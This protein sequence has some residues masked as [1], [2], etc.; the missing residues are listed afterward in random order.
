MN[1]I[2]HRTEEVT[3]TEIIESDDGN[4]NFT[5]DQLEQLEALL[6][7]E[8]NSLWT[9]VLYGIN[10]TDDQIVAIVEKVENGRVYTIEGNSGDSCRRRD[11]PLGFYEILGYGI[12]AY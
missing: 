2:D 8:N 5:D 10:A 7:D 11:H 9:A 3:E 12:P 1:E 4:G 6:D